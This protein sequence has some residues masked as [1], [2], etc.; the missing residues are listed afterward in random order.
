MDNDIFKEA[1]Y[2]VAGVTR[3]AYHQQ[4]KQSQKVKTREDLI[5]ENVVKF[6]KRHSRMGS[7]VLFYA[8]KVEGIGV[9]KFETL[10][11]SRGL[12][13]KHKQKRIVTTT[14]RY[15][16]TD[17]NL[18]NG[19]TI[20]NINQV[21]AG[22]I[23]YFKSGVKLFYIFTLKDAYSKRIVGLYGSDN[24]LAINAVIT[25]RQVITLRKKDNL[26]NMIH[27][28][29]AGT[30]YKS[31]IYK[32]LLNGCK[33]RMSI[34]DNCLQNGMAEQ[35]N[36]IVKN[37]YMINENITTIKGLNKALHKI[38]KLINEERPVKALDYKTP[39]EYEKWIAGLEPSE[40][41]ITK[42]YDF[43]ENQ[44]TQKRELQ[45]GIINKEVN[46]NKLNKPNIKKAVDLPE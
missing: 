15:E 10:L 22:D 32:A 5:V 45:K 9:N 23:T 24:M 43:V 30:Q 11:S 1:I 2:S 39:V 12:S 13:A 19:L 21:I 37:H 42:L 17:V 7:R 25:L 27:H 34:A 26:C 41:P 29:D 36:D 40:R 14:G 44:N 8:I 3:Q 31:G 4:I 20:S 18:I 6:R 35:L 46:L 28:S 33:I 16:D 38:K